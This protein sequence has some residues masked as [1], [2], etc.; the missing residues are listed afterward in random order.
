MSQVLGVLSLTDHTLTI[1]AVLEGPYPDRTDKNWVFAGGLDNVVYGWHPSIEIGAIDPERDVRLHLHTS[2]P[3]PASFHGMRGS[4]NGVRYREEWWF[5]THAVIYRPGQMRKYL[6]RIVVLDKDLS[7]IV[8]YSLPFTFE[9][10]SDIEYCLGLKVA[11]AG[12][13]FGYSV[14]DRSTKLMHVGWENVGYLFT[15]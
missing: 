6:H 5:V 10:G 2:I 3:S 7:A 11:D 13:V 9:E 4:S 12:M 15:V 14:R 1:Q 8:R